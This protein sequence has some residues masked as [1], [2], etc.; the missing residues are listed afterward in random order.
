VQNNNFDSSYVKRDFTLRKGHELPTFENGVLTKLFVC[1]K[2]EVSALLE[3]Y[4]RRNFVIYVGHF[5][6]G[7]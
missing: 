1:E 5:V 4:I 6:L 7:W 2:D 3:C